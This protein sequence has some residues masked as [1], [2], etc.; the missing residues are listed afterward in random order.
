MAELA[1]DVVVSAGQHVHARASDMKQ[2]SCCCNPAPGSKHRMWLQPLAPGMARLRVSQPTG[3]HRDLHG[4]R[5]D[6]TRRTNRSLA[7]AP[8]QCLRACRRTASPRLLRVTDD[9]LPDDAEVLHARLREHLQL[10]GADPLRR[11]LDGQVR[12][13]AQC[14]RR[15]W[16]EADL[17]QGGTTTRQALLGSACRLRAMPCLRCRVIP[18]PR[19]CAWRAMSCPPSAWRWEPVSLRQAKRSRWQPPSRW[20]PR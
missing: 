8:L 13:G 16:R 11:C 20:I 5:A 9:H 3:L 7:A 2:G 17:P 18:C 12:P 19:W 4:Q 14:A 1:P 6:R 10:R 15:L